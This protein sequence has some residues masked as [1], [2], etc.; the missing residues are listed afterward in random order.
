M[1]FETE[2]IQ[3]KN[4]FDLMLNEKTAQVIEES[5]QEKIKNLATVQE[6]NE[7][8]GKWTTIQTEFQTATSQLQQVC[9]NQLI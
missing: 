9:R 5:V 8:R 4:S 6:L 3:L 7:L 1:K 2:W